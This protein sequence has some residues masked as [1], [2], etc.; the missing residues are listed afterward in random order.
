MFDYIQEASDGE[1]IKGCP[2]TLLWGEFLF[3]YWDWLARKDFENNFTTLLEVNHNGND[4]I[5]VNWHV[6][7]KYKGHY[8]GIGLTRNMVNIGIYIPSCNLYCEEYSCFWYFNRFLGSVESCVINKL[9]V[10]IGCLYDRYFV[11]HSWNSVHSKQTYM[12]LLN[13]CH[14]NETDPI[15]KSV[16]DSIP[17]C[18]YREV[19]EDTGIHRVSYYVLF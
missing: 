17:Q 8:A 13:K 1:L 3:D 9:K 5:F 19:Y 16:I 4:K 7:D 6:S 11:D 12:C 18:V 14:H 15:P 2:D 10:G